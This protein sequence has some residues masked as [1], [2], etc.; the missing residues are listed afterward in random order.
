MTTQH[1]DDE[2]KHHDDDKKKPAGPA[3][4]SQHGSRPA[5]EPEKKEGTA[6]PL[7]QPPDSPLAPGGDT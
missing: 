6:D 4:T 2:K 7:G 1:H 5:S 3:T